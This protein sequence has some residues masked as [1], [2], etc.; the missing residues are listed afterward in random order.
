[1]RRVGPYELRELLGRGGM[2]AVWLARDARGGEVALKLVETGEPDA[3]RARRFAREVAALR[4]L[5]HPHVVRVLDAG[6][7]GQYAW[8][9]L[10]RVEGETLEARLGRGPLP[11]PE[12]LRLGRELGDALCAVHR[13]GL[14]HRDLKPDNVLIERGRA[15][16]SLERHDASGVAERSSASAPANVLIERHDASGV[17][18]RSS[19]SAPAN[20]LCGPRGFVLVDFGLT[21]DLEVEESLRLSRSGALMGTPGFWS[22]EQA[23][24][25]P[26]GPASDIY[27]LGATLY[28]ALTGE[29]PVQG[30]SFLDVVVATRTQ[31]PRPPS[32][33]RPE[34]PAWLE[35]V[36]LRCLAKDPAERYPDAVALVDALEAPVASPRAPRGGARLALAALALAGAAAVGVAA[37]RRGDPAPESSSSA[38]SPTP[39]ASAGPT[40][41]A[42]GPTP[43]ASGPTPEASGPTPEASGPTPE[44]SVGPTPTSSPSPAATANVPS[45]S[46]PRPS[47]SPSGA[48]SPGSA[49]SAVQVALERGE[50]GVARG[51]IERALALAPADPV[52]IGARAW[53][54][55][56]EL[57]LKEAQRDIDRLRGEGV[58]ATLPAEAA[59]HAGRAW[60][61]FEPYLGDDT[62]GGLS[63]ARSFF[64]LAASRA[65]QVAA[66][67]AWLA[68]AELLCGADPQ[69]SLERA[70]AL[71]PAD[72]ALRFVRGALLRAKGDDAGAVA[73]LRAAEAAA[74]GRVLTR[75]ELAQ[76][77][78]EVA[79][80]EREPARSADRSEAQ[81]LLVESAA[82]HR[83]DPQLL[84]SWA[85]WLVRRQEEVPEPEPRRDQELARAEGLL[86]QALDIHGRTYRAR[87][88][89]ARCLRLRGDLEGALRAARM[90]RAQ[91][92][93][94]RA[95]GVLFCMVGLD[96][97]RARVEAWEPAFELI[98]A[99]E[100]AVEECQ[101]QATP[102][103]AALEVLALRAFGQARS[104]GA[105]DARAQRAAAMRGITPE[106]RALRAWHW[107]LCRWERSRSQPELDLLPAVQALDQAMGLAP[108]PLR[109]QMR[110][111]RAFLGH[112]TNHEERARQ[113]ALATCREA[114]RDDLQVA[115]WRVMLTAA[116][117]P[118]DAPLLEALA[119]AP[120]PHVA[121]VGAI[122]LAR[123]GRERLPAALSLAR[124]ECER[125]PGH[126]VARTTL[127]LLQEVAEDEAGALESW[128]AAARAKPPHAPALLALGEAL[129]RAGR[130]AEA[131]GAF[132]QAATLAPAAARDGIQR[133][134]AALKASGE[135]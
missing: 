34:V 75:I 126:P 129:L 97:L 90:V 99:A 132:A 23:A 105:V 94:H 124:A 2:G 117:R 24:G 27:S 9:A 51:Q 13:L 86:R 64:Q 101:L 128:T 131:R 112:R 15:A 5:A 40:P 109:L 74:P 20:V 45:G 100:R 37:G 133:A 77:L 53:L 95:G 121:M 36:V 79:A 49:W 7:E 57:R 22:P 106:L 50:L 1:M 104:W 30:G 111:L 84:A 120:S 58:F 66:Y 119:R 12:A 81:R 32:Q 108:P 17:A 127:A 26:A 61:E 55:S 123:L 33:L 29:A 92:S 67:S 52:A 102:V 93:R 71:D 41:E 19:A 88:E 125:L 73:E 68:Y 44:A 113:L 11:L 65:P 91:R 60:L 89:L 16:A 31:P 8:M 21:K 82:V 14:V 134:E 63:G 48:P 10:E 115:C 72:P 18:E 110:C 42:S 118:E 114:G 54:E 4:R 38:P 59:Y 107:A 83:G 98:D 35:R 80:G 56:R 39:A 6:Q 25:K 103:A 46:D 43:E 47:A 96:V 116:P 122:G 130:A 76:A 69:P 3:P 87:F 85:A 28:A 135:D 70:R 78:V 62:P